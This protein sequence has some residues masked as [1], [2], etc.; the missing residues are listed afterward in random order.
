MIKRR[1]VIYTIIA[2]LLM[3]STVG[4]AS[5]SNYFSKV[6]GNLIGQSFKMLVYDDNGNNTMTVNGKK[7][8]IELLKNGANTNSQSTGFKSEVLDITMDGNQ[9]THVG[10][11]T[12]F[13]EKGLQTIQ[14]FDFTTLAEVNSIEG[15]SG[16]I[17]I[18]RIANKLANSI[19][20]KK[21]IIV[22]SQS[23]IIVGVYEGDKVYIEIPE[24]LPKMTRINIDGKSLY[25]Y[26][27][28]YTIINTELLK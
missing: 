17:P 4:C 18:D 16:L 23:G 9:I 15:S 1:I 19:G 6:K 12:V 21:T 2:V 24:D 22:K 11:T 28:D 7:F 27:A 20:L 3:L 14:D 26:R 8:S 25:I 13:A 10:S 5:I